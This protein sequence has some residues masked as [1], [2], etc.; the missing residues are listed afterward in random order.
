MPRRRR[1][2]YVTRSPDVCLFKP[3]GR[4]LSQIEEVIILV[5]EFEAMHLK[6]Y[7]GLSQ[8]ECAKKMNISQPTFHR[9]I[10]SLRNK[11]SIAF[12]EGKAIKIEGGSFFMKSNYNK[13]SFKVAIC[14][15]EQ[16]IDGEIASRLGRCNYFI[17]VEIE[18][19]KVKKHEAIS[20]PHSQIQRGAGVEVAQMLAKTKVEIVICENIGPRALDVL[21]QFNIK[22]LNEKGSIKKALEDLL[23]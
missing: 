17:I 20:N 14:S 8:E 5:E 19:G 9:L 22:V 12:V 10:N 11:I 15:D 21:E 3:A 16:S 23:K 18:N 2:R 1:C 13:R 4:P 7:L 6:D